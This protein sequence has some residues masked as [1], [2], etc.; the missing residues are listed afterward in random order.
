[1]SSRTM[2]PKGEGFEVNNGVRWFQ[3]AATQTGCDVELE[4]KTGE[5]IC[6]PFTNCGASDD[7][8]LVKPFGSAELVLLREED[9]RAYY[10]E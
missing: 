1:M 4:V 9:M 5:L 7:V 2:Y 8:W 10:W 3:E 6:K